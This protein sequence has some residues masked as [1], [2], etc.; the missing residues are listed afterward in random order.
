VVLECDE[1]KDGYVTGF[2]KNIL[3]T[4]VAGI[5]GAQMLEL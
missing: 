1:C 2:I 3:T 4:A 5:F